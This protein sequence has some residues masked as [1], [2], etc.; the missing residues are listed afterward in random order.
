MATGLVIHISSGKDKHTQV[1]TDEHVRIGNCEDCDFIVTSPCTKILVGPRNYLPVLTF[2]HFVLES[3]KKSRV[4]LNGRVATNILEVW[5]C[6][7]M[8]T[9]VR[10]SV[11]CNT[12]KTVMASC[13]ACR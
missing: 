7:D 13:E 8:V 6:D 3:C 12:V 11:R 5:K 1:L 10:T 4:T 2:I 9:L